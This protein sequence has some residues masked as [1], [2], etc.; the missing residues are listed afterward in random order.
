MHKKHQIFIISSTFNQL[1]DTDKLL[2]SISKQSYPYIKTYIVDDGSTDGTADFIKSKYKNITVL[3]GNGKLWWTGAIYWGVEEILK[4][5][6]Q[7]DFILTINNDCQFNKDY[8]ANL[9]RESLSYHRA[10]VG[11][12]I[13]DIHSKTKIADAGV[14][15]DWPKCQLIPLGPQSTKDL[16]KNISV[17][18][19]IDTLSTKGTLYPL[20]VFQKIGNFDKKHLPHYISDYEFAC[21]AKRAGFKIVLSYNCKVY[22]NISRTGIGE[23]LPDSF[24]F[25][26]LI[27]LCLSRRSRIN[28]IDH[29]WFITLCCPSR[30]KPNNYI[31]LIKKVFY[32]VLSLNLLHYLVSKIIKLKNQ[33]RSN[34]YFLK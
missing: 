22:N 24:S 32:I 7:E 5:A 33:I 14:Q 21:R 25:P 27:K 30:Y 10:I 23:K 31:C 15:I 2:H 4:N 34:F 12:L 26:Q 28:I 3:F 19:N 1:D 16:P 6:S 29:F 11:S 18:E 8:I 20:E 13:I 17:Q 9:I